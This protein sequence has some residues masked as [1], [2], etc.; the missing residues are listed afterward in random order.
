MW[1]LSQ[2]SSNWRSKAIT[3]LKGYIN[4]L[5]LVKQLLIGSAALLMISMILG[6]LSQTPG[7]RFLHY[8]LSK[9]WHLADLHRRAPTE[10]FSASK[11]FPTWWP[12][13]CLRGLKSRDCSRTYSCHPCFTLGKSFSI[14]TCHSQW[15]SAH[16]SGLIGFPS[17][18]YNLWSGCV[19]SN[20][21]I[22]IAISAQV[23]DVSRQLW[24]RY[25][26]FVSV[27]LIL[28]CVYSINKALYDG[29]ASWSS[30]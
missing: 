12:S 4:G 8:R 13:P 17:Y 22:S 20:Q 5:G 30:V 25:M 26:S 18:H 7:R 19:V 14:E 9:W 23:A 2:I 29:Q 3:V 6:L 27:C 15:L 11:A 21:A 16:S 10:L 1:S 24:D 28:L